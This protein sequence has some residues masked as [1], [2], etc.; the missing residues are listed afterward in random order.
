MAIN[1]SPQINYPNSKNQQS[2]E[3]GMAFQDFVCDLLRDEFGIVITNYS[4]AKMQLGTGENKQGIEIK[5]DRLCSSTNRLSIE[6]AEKTRAS[7]YIWANSGIYRNDNSWLYIQG[8]TTKRIVVFLFAKSILRM[9]HQQ[10]RFQEHE[11]PT[12]RAFYLPF[13]AATKYAAKVIIK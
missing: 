4:S 3:D 13:E 5:L 10:K 2:Y 7:N 9:L 12:V 11:E 1:Y 8:T 6:I